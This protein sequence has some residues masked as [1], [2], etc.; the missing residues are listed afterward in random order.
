MAL[1]V[2][3][4]NPWP[5]EAVIEVT[6]RHKAAGGFSFTKSGQTS[7]QRIR[8]GSTTASFNWTARVDATLCSS[9]D[10]WYDVKV[11]IVKPALDLPG[12]IRNDRY[13]TNKIRLTVRK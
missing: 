4:K 3:L 10:I 8:P 13:S 5:A 7:R 6:P 11:R 9:A 12:L 2:R 1:T